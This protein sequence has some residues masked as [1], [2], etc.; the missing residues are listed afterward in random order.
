MPHVQFPALYKQATVPYTCNSGIW[1][2]EAGRSGFKEILNL[3]SNLMLVC[4][5][6][7]SIPKTSVGH[8]YESSFIYKSEF[9]WD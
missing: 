1:E 5:Q 8:L 4:V 6:N 2:V 9:Q 3:H 7:S